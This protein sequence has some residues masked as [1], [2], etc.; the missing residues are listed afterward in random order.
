MNVAHASAR[1][2]STFVFRMRPR[3][4][5]SDENG[6]G[7]VRAKAPSTLEQPSPYSCLAWE[8]WEEPMIVRLRSPRE[9]ERSQHARVT[10]KSDAF[11]APLTKEI[12]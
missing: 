9:G 10:S 12:Q 4:T 11:C 6:I 1:A 5:D 8:R 2:A 7:E 3:R